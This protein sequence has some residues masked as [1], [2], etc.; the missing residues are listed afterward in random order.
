MI[1]YKINILNISNKNLNFG[2]IFFNYKKQKN[3]KIKIRTQIN[4]LN[5]SMDRDKNF[6]FDKRKAPN[7]IQ[8]LFKN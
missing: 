2:E 8:I 1:P 6:L 5:H 7:Q 3:K 4:Q